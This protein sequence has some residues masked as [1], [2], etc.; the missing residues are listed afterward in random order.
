MRHHVISFDNALSALTTQ[1]LEDPAVQPP[2][3][4]G[5]TRHILIPIATECFSGSVRAALTRAYETWGDDQAQL[6][7]AD[8]LDAVDVHALPETRPKWKS[9]LHEACL[10]IETRVPPALQKPSGDVPEDSEP[11]RKLRLID[12][13]ELSADEVV[14]RCE[15]APFSTLLDLIAREEKFSFFDWAD[16]I[17]RLAPLLETT[18]IVRLVKT[19]GQAPRGSFTLAKLSELLLER[20]DRQ[21]A[22]EAAVLA[23][24]QAPS[25]GWSRWTEGGSCLAAF[26]AM[27]KID[28]QRTIPLAFARL[29]IDGGGDVAYLEE[30]L[31]LLSPTVPVSEVWNEIE[32]YCRAMF[33]EETLPDDAPDITTSPESDTTILALS[34]LLLLIMDH[35]VTSIAQNVRRFSTAL[36]L[37]NDAAMLETVRRALQG[38]DALREQALVILS[39]VATQDRSLVAGFVE[40][41]GICAKSPDYLIRKLAT[42]LLQRS[43]HPTVTGDLNR[44]RLPMIYDLALPPSNVPFHLPRPASSAH[45]ALPDTNEPEDLVSPFNDYL[46]GLSRFAGVGVRN[47]VFRTAQIM[48]ELSPQSEWSRSAEMALWGVLSSAG[49]KRA[50]RRPRPA[51]ARRASLRA[52]AELLDASRIT[53]RQLRELEHLCGFY[54]ARI[55]RQMPDRRIANTSPGTSR[56]DREERADWLTPDQRDLAALPKRLDD[57]RAVLGEVTTLKSLD[58]DLAREVRE[59]AVLVSPSR[60]VG[61]AR[62]LS[63]EGLKTSDYAAFE[64]DHGRE[65]LIIRNQ[66]PSSGTAGTSWIAINPCGRL[67]PCRDALVGGRAN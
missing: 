4:I 43:S 22:W 66:A 30:I 19:L 44:A 32:S 18:E 16:V 47:A 24:E 54:D 10:A 17:E 51:I 9:A 62:F 29:A 28:P 31:P 36:V 6:I 2:W 67:H 41:L 59:G 3:P 8:L 39:S 26:E 61:D 33:P 65:S 56:R 5:L 37:A 50:F 52:A 64:S 15:T 27:R 1:S 13:L 53:E 60:P 57:G 58:W 11:I 38:T 63:V 21:H 7:L 46:R 42:E 55:E 48:G 14:A 23:T 40:Q 49:L 12:G 34:D 45:E 20:G 35:P 25:S